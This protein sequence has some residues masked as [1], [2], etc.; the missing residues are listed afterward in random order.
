MKIWI[1]AALACGLAMAASSGVD[2]YSTADLHAIGQKLAAKG[3][4]FQ[5]ENLQHYPGHYTMMAYRSATGSSE[6]H[7]HEADIFVVETGD[8]TL[9]TGGKIVSPHVEKP[10]EIRGSSIEGGE[11]HTVRAGDIVHIPANTP[12]Q[13]LITNGKPFTYFVVKVTGQ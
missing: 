12:H 10:G 1:C 4:R 6:L 13:L 3:Q 7:Q 8:A 9:V 5:S 2:V 11:R